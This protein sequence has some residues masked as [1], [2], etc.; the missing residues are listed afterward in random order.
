MIRSASKDLC[1]LRLPPGLQFDVVTFGLIP[2][3]SVSGPYIRSIFRVQWTL[4][5]NPEVTTSSKA[6]KEAA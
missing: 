3:V 5:N 4:G 6:W 2:S 1:D